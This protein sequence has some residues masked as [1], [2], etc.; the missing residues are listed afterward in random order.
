[1]E[2]RHL[3][4]AIR[5]II[6]VDIFSGM[7]LYSNKGCDVFEKVEVPNWG[8]VSCGLTLKGKVSFWL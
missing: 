2:G 6:A 3:G 8:A 1:M 7:V 4:F 5:G